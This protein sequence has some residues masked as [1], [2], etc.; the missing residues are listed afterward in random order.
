MSYRAVAVYCAP[1]WAIEVTEGL[2]PHMFAHTQTRRLTAVDRTAREVIAELMEV[3]PE[4][5]D[6]EVTI[7]VPSALEDVLAEL[8]EAEATAERASLAVS[9]CRARAARIA[10]DEGFTAHETALLLGVS[11]RRRTDQPR[12][13]AL[14]ATA[15]TIRR[16]P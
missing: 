16:L 13:P 1:W 6:V 3:D 12:D 8:E 5:V 10:R 11:H 14:P 7:T 2:P 9:G 4:N 15:A